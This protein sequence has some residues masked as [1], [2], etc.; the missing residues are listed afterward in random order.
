MKTCGLDVHKDSIFC[1]IYDEKE[2]SVE[3]FGTFTPEL[4][5][6]CQYINGLGITKAAMESTGIYIDAVR[7]VLRQGGVGS[8]VVNPYLIK[9][10]PGRKSDVKDSVWIA[11]LSHKQMLPSSFI[12]DGVL[13]ELRTY[14]RSY[15]RLVQKRAKTL[16]AI[17]RILV[18]GGIRLSSVVSSTSTKSFID[19]ARA[20]SE[21]ETSPSALLALLHGRVRSKKGVSD[22]LAGCIEPRHVWQLKQAFSEFDLWDKM[23]AETVE[24]MECLSM[25]HYHEELRLLQTIPGIDLTA[26]VCIIAETGVDMDAFGSSGRLVGWAGLRPRND[27]SAGKYKSTATTRGNAHL[28]PMLV[29]CAWG[30]QRTNGSKF[31]RDFLRL[32]ARKS[33]K[34]AAVA[35]ARKL[36]VTIYAVLKSRKEYSAEVAGDGITAEQAARLAARYE[37]LRD[38]YA[39]MAA[40]GKESGGEE[41]TAASDGDHVEAAADLGKQD[42]ARQR[43]KAGYLCGS[44]PTDTVV[45]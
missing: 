1:A 40:D 30:A 38:R 25:E 37:R 36:L 21:G 43:V 19:V 45:S 15:R 4:R 14:T 31:Q 9:Q 10:M 41:K 16:T 33:S 8:V 22:A 2:S 35:I 34:K 11:K 20:V 12:P 6:M 3:K 32:S 29:Q 23:T 5:R 24:K 26:A 13:S 18:S 27:E 17:D 39:A 42:N 28:K 44:S 7:T